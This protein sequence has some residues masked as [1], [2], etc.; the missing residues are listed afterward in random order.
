[1]S[2]VSRDQVPIPSRIDAIVVFV[3]CYFP[4][5]IGFTEVV[6]NSWNGSTEDQERNICSTV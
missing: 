5:G 2:V 3:Q 6:I 4:T 1:M